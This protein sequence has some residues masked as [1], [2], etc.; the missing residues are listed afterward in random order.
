MSV[1]NSQVGQGIGK[2]ILT[3]IEHMLH[4][5]YHQLRSNPWMLWHNG[6]I[7]FVLTHWL[8]NHQDGSI[9][10]KLQYRQDN[11]VAPYTEYKCMKCKTNNLILILT[12]TIALTLTLTITDPLTPYFIRPLLNKLAKSGRSVAGLEGAVLPDLKPFLRQFLHIF[13]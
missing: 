8:R 7:W 9:S 4:K 3:G 11:S 13:M 10:R 12:L 1:Q 5:A 2:S 6:L